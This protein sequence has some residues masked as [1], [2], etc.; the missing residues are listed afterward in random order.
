V[1][2]F[3]VA[4]ILIELATEVPVV[5]PQQLNELISKSIFL[6]NKVANKFW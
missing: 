1:P 6:Y 2:E 3:L 4:K 5:H